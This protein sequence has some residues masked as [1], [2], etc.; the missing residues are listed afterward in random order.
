LLKAADAQVKAR[1]GK[2]M[3]SPIKDGNVFQQQFELG[4]AAGIDFMVRIPTIAIEGARAI[5]EEH[6]SANETEKPG[7][8][9]G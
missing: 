6:R 4:E 3:L 7:P 9:S 1:R 8:S 5:I 2:Y